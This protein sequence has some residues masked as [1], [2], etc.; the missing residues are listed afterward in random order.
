MSY[1][2]FDIETIGQPEAEIRAKLP[3]FDPLKVP[4]G[5]ATKPETIER[6]REQ[7]R[8]TYGDDIVANAGLDPRYGKVAISG[9]RTDSFQAQFSIAT[10]DD[11]AEVLRETWRALT[12]ERSD[13]IIGFNVKS[14]DLRFCVVRSWI[15]G[16]PVSRSVFDPTN[17]RCPFHKRVIDLQE[18]LA[19]GDYGKR[20]SSLDDALRMLLL[21]PKFGKGS[22]FPALWARDKQ[23]ALAYNRRDL[24]CEEALAKRLGV[25]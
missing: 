16:I 11:E 9:I 7:S 23:A 6:I 25:I 19:A 21:P 22:D 18:V 24:E 15:L 8:A 13:W 2:I 10:V 14:F 4:L 1:A 20:F 17:F 12:L 3:P 5:N